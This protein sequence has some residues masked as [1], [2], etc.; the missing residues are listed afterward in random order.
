[1]VLLQFL[2]RINLKHTRE[3]WRT[4]VSW[5]F[6]YISG[7]EVRQSVLRHPKIAI[8]DKRL[9]QVNSLQ[10]SVRYPQEVFLAQLI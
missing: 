2:C 6:F 1:M 4:I 9:I 8:Y 3:K 5:F 10:N 7:A